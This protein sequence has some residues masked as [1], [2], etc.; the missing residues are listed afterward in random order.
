MKSILFLVVM[1]AAGHWIY[2]N[3]FSS[4]M[5]GTWQS[6]KERTLD[7]WKEDGI[8]S[9]VRSQFK[10]ILGLGQLDISQSTWRFSLQGSVDSS[11]YDVL[12]N[13]GQ[14]S[15]LLIRDEIH[16]TCV[17]GDELHVSMASFNST[18]IFTRR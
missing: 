18:E 4:P 10:P 11:Q 8:D 1:A 2:T 6:N 14:C 16:D 17:Y 3:Y 7:Q 13:R 5:L 12:A 9:R 15:Q